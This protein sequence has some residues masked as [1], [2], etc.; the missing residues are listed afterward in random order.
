MG[1]SRGNDGRGAVHRAQT[2]KYV[3]ALSVIPDA[4]RS[5]G[6]STCA[7]A[8]DAVDIPGCAAIDEHW[9]AVGANPERAA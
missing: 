8:V 7:T 9:T 2:A 1:G 6:T 4:G 5:G 3:V